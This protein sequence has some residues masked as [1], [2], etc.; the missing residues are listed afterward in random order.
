MVNI[1]DVSS[2]DDDGYQLGGPSISSEELV[3][4]LNKGI[5]DSIQSCGQ[6]LP[7]SAIATNNSSPFQCEWTTFSSDLVCPA[8]EDLRQY[9]LRQYEGHEYGSD[10]R[11]LLYAT[12]LGLLLSSR[13]T[14]NDNDNSNDQKSTPLSTFLS[15]VKFLIEE[16]GLNPNQ[17][18][19][20]TGACER[21]PLHLV[22]RS[23]HPAA[24]HL[25][26]SRGANPNMT[27]DEGWT[28][29]MACCLPDIPSYEKGG[30]SIEERLATLTLLLKGNGSD[31]W[32]INVNARNYCG[33]TALHYACEGLNHELIA[34]LLDIGDADA[35][36]RTIWGQSCIGLIRTYS[37]DDPERAMKCKEVIMNYLDETGEIESIRSILEEERKSIDLMEFVSDVLIPASRRRDTDESENNKASQDERI[38]SALLKYLDISPDVLFDKKAFQSYPHEDANLYEII[39]QKIFDLVP[40]ALRQ[41]YI[42]HPTTEERET[43]LCTQF[44]VRKEAE[45]FNE[46]DARR[47]DTQEVMHRAFK[48]HRERGRIPNQLELLNDI[49]VSPL[50]HTLAFGTPSNAVLKEIIEHAG[51]GIVEMG[52]GT[53]YWSYILSRLG[54]DVVAYDMSPTQDLREDTSNEYFGSRTFFSVQEGDASTVFGGDNSTDNSDRALLLVWPNN[55]DAVDNSHVAIEG[56]T[57]PDIWDIDCLQKYHE[58]G[59]ET[60]IYCGESESKIELMDG[61]TP[62]CGFCSSRKF[63][64]FLQ[65]NY[66]LEVE[67]KCPQ[68]WMKVDDVTIWKRK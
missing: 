18:T 38:V 11:P 58:S 17:P 41:V 40:L 49:I 47:V 3:D 56:S 7:S 29:L 8:V 60:V 25:L 59:G 57:L 30:P 19:S 55:P 53:G 31:D 37:E 32:E 23:C 54:A 4:A 21:P 66:A 1:D 35:T 13:S 14:N 48:V 6:V 5:I 62:D 24:V 46:E 12:C 33:Y 50:Q 9:D 34:C 42:N 10:G 15:I 45:V 68:W 67:L 22:S 63:Q 64:T 26:L 61:A 44:K 65:E 51:P 28:A 16:V 52:A 36:M 39:H 27:D 43:I 2:S 20:T